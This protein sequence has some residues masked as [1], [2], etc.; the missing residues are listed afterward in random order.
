MVKA[1]RRRVVSCKINRQSVPTQSVQHEL[2]E[3]KEEEIE[4]AGQ[5]EPNPFLFC[6]VGSRASASWKL[7]NQI[8]STLNAN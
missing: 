5:S 8:Y 2:A 3:R 6:S 4:Q 1:S 7:F